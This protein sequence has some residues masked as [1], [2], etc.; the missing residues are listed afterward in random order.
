MQI[1]P[2]L[3]LP[4][5]QIPAAC[6][7]GEFIYLGRC[8]SFDLKHDSAKQALEAKLNEF[9]KINSNLKIRVQTKPKI[10]I[11]EL[12]LRFYS[13]YCCTICL[14]PAGN[15][16]LMLFALDLCETGWKCPSV[17]V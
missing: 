17:P 13:T 15:R 7:R 14:L 12:I 6:L 1:M 2:N 8:F 16:N 10:L 3:C 5:G 4:E 11:S 9:I